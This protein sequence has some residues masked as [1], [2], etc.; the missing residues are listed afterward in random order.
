[1]YIMYMLYF[2]P[3]ALMLPKSGLGFISKRYALFCSDNFT[4]ALLQGGEKLLFSLYIFM[5]IYEHVPREEVKTT[6]LNM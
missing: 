4:G 2:L 5:G 1:M 6:R 3:Y